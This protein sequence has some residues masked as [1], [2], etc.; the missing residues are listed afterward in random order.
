MSLVQIDIIR[1]QPQ[2][3][4]IDRFHNMLARQPAIIRPGPGRPVH[5]GKN[6]DPLPPLIRERLPQHLLRLGLGIDIGRIER[7]DPLFERRPHT[8]NRS[9]LLHLRP[10]RDPIAI[11]DLTNDEAALAK[12]TMVHVA[13]TPTPV[14]P[15][16]ARNLS[17]ALDSTHL[18]LSSSASHIANLMASHPASANT[19]LH[20]RLW[21]IPKS[22]PPAPK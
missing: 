22:S 4:A 12:M 16:A 19:V 11:G 21:T 3:A 14:I 17:H 20:P 10:V 6:L 7:G 18:T 1:P 9:L 2:Q 13:S 5:L 15:S 8:G